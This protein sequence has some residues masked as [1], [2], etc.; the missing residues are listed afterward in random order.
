MT[1]ITLACLATALGALGAA[2]GLLSLEVRS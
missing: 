2:L 1:A